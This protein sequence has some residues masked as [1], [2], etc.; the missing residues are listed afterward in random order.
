MSQTLTDAAIATTVDSGKSRLNR[1]AL[2][3]R[4]IGLSSWWRLNR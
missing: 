4:V 1:T 3:L 2:V